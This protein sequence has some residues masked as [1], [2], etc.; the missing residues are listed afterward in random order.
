MILFLTGALVRSLS[1]RK[2]D[3]ASSSPD[4]STFVMS[5]NLRFSANRRRV[6][7][8]G[9]TTSVICDI[10]VVF[11][12]ASKQR[13][14]ME[15]L[16]RCKSFEHVSFVLCRCVPLLQAIR[17]PV[18]TFRKLVLFYS[19]KESGYVSFWFAIGDAVWNHPPIKSIK[20]N[21]F[22][23]LFLCSPTSELRRNYW[24]LRCKNRAC[25]WLRPKLSEWCMANLDPEEPGPSLDATGFKVS[26]ISFLFY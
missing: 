4:F 25:W 2:V 18:P 15:Y 22:S 21:M 14:T 23:T 16:R 7:D 5:S 3:M 24:W 17:A 12:Q 9:L 26:A 20:K 1:L 8:D 6:W 10:V 11:P 13:S 19:Q